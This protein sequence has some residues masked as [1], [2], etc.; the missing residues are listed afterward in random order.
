[1]IHIRQRV[2]VTIGLENK[3]NMGGHSK[4]NFCGVREEMN[5]DRP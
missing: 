1:M 3:E 5:R 4:S 2:N